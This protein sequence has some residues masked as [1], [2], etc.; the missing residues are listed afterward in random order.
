M[1]RLGEVAE[2]VHNLLF[3]NISIEETQ[4]TFSVECIHKDDYYHI[5]GR[6]IIEKSDNK[7]SFAY[8]N[9]LDFIESDRIYPVKEVTKL[10]RV[11]DDAIAEV[12]ESFEDCHLNFG[13]NSFIKLKGPKEN[14][15]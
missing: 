1:I 5:K 10:G 9:M 12:L 14:G 15:N 4:N 2:N 3:G 8:I 11:N 13:Y 6:F 7:I